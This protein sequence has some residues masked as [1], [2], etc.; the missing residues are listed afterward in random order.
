MYNA[1]P[2]W[3]SWFDGRALLLVVIAISVWVWY[4]NGE[5]DDE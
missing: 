5:S 2:W 1:L 4:L 3:L